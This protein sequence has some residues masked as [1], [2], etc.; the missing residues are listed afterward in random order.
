[1]ATIVNNPAPTNN[2]GNGMGFLIG[3]VLLIV[4]VF[5][6]FYYGFPLLSNMRGTTVNVPNK[7][8]VNVHNSK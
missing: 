8:D 4:F 6:L 5:I 3:V 2:S 1:M 7:L